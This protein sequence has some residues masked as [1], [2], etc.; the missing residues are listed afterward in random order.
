MKRAHLGLLTLA[1]LAVAACEKKP[2]PTMHEPELPAQATQPP[3]APT[4]PMKDPYASEPAQRST[5][6]DVIPPPPA[7]RTGQP[8]GTRKPA[9]A[10]PKGAP[11]THVVQ[12]GDTLFSIAKQY[13]G[14]GSKWKRIQDANPQIASD[15]KKLQAGA[16]LT[17]P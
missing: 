3:P 1:V 6:T 9:A 14:D 5:V 15:P 8:A 7:A 11:R 17:I 13:Y 2:E 10:T 12:K 16:T 4:E